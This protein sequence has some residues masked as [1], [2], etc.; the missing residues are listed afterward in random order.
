[1]GVDLTTHFQGCSTEHRHLSIGVVVVNGTLRCLPALEMVHDSIAEPT[2]YFPGS[3]YVAT[4][5]DTQICQ[6]ASQIARACHSQVGAD[7]SRTDFTLQANNLAVCS[8]GPFP[9]ISQGSLMTFA[10]GLEGST[11]DSLLL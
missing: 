7:F 10:A 8:I 6:H 11:V 1:M 2:M 4:N 3:P 9:C 5:L